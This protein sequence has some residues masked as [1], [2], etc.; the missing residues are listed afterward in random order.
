MI[1]LAIAATL[2]VLGAMLTEPPGA[3]MALALA[4]F[5]QSAICAAIAK[6]PDVRVASKLVGVCAAGLLFVRMLDLGEYDKQPWPV[7]AM[8]LGCLVA[9]ALMATLVMLPPPES[10]PSSPG[11]ALLNRRV[12]LWQDRVTGKLRVKVDG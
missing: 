6:T 2:L 9:G 4:T 11:R 7:V 1:R 10:L 5:V 3:S 8:A 12:R